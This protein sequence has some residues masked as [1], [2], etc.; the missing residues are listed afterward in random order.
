MLD[1]GHVAYQVLLSLKEKEFNEYHKA[2]AIYLLETAIR[3][4]QQSQTSE[5]L[6]DAAIKSGRERFKLIGR[7]NVNCGIY[8]LM[9][10]CD[11]AFNFDGMCSSIQDI[12]DAKDGRYIKR[13]YSIDELP[14]VIE[15]ALKWYNYSRQERKVNP[16]LLHILAVD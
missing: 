14:S 15:N 11:N 6:L 16:I 9:E 2:N 3:N 5:G 4:C 1:I 8:E 12:K 10:W 13:T 7:A